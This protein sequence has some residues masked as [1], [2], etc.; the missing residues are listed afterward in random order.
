MFTT[1][2]L[3]LAH[4][5]REEVARRVSAGRP[6][7]GSGGWGEPRGRRWSSWLTRVLRARPGVDARTARAGGA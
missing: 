6:E 2:D 4:D 7:N 1:M 3:T 5:R